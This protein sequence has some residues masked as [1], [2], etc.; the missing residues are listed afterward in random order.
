MMQYL[1]LTNFWHMCGGTTLRPTI[2][3]SIQCWRYVRYLEEHPANRRAMGVEM[4]PDGAKRVRRKPS[5][6]VDE[7]G[8]GKHLSSFCLV[9]GM[10]CVRFGG[11]N[12]GPMLL[13]TCREYAFIAMYQ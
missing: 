9:L 3:I 1:I 7:E 13:S 10:L 11:V 4:L 6:L 2:L 8:R 12:T 5:R